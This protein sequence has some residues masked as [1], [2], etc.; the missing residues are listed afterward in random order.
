MICRKVLDNVVHLCFKKSSHFSKFHF[1]KEH[2][3]VLY[4]IDFYCLKK[5]IWLYLDTIDLIFYDVLY[6]PS[7]YVQNAGY[8]PGTGQITPNSLS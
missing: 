7:G 6:R 5:Q 1:S 4:E 3:S 2:K 8:V